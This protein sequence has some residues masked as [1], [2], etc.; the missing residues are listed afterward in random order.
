MEIFDNALGDLPIQ[1]YKNIE[2]EANYANLLLLFYYIYVVIISHTVT[3]AIFG[4]SACAI[5]TPCS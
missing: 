3:F 4:V 1:I 5:L 2:V